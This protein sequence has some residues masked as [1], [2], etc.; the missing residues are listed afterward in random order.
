MKFTI[1]SYQTIRDGASDQTNNRNETSEVSNTGCRI[2]LGCYAGRCQENSH[3][4]LLLLLAS[5]SKCASVTGRYVSQSHPGLNSIKESTET[6]GSGG[7][8]MIRV[9]CS[10]DSYHLL[11]GHWN[12]LS[13]GGLPQVGYSVLK[14]LLKEMFT[15]KKMT[16]QSLSPHPH[17][18]GNLP[19]SII[20]LFLT[21]VNLWQ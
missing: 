17:A 4:R 1:I 14:G 12:K 16:I 15:Q 13:R 21:C 10:F 8:Y 5:L 20:Y 6:Y 7:S 19:S 9:R 3:L 18:D 11:S 2:P